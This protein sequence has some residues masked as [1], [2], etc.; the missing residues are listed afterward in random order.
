MINVNMIDI[1]TGKSIKGRSVIW[2]DK[3]SIF[4]I[5]GQYTAETDDGILNGEMITVDLDFG[6][7]PLQR[8]K[9]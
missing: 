4:E 1:S 8:R 7:S 5:A 3:K 2:N 6:I 9:G